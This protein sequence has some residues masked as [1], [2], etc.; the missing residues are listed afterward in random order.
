VVSYVRGHW[1]T[2]STTEAGWA[3]IG[4]VGAMEVRDL[5]GFT[6]GVGIPRL[7]SG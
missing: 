7:R 1:R 2:K 5:D 3:S 6:V 4:K